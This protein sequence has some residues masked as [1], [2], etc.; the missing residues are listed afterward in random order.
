MAKKK[1]AKKAVKKT[2]KKTT[3]KSAKKSTRRKGR[4]EQGHAAHMKRVEEMGM[5]EK[6]T[7]PIKVVF[8]GAGSAFLERLFVDLLSMPGARKGEIALVDID[9]ERL[10]L[11]QQM[12]EKVI[13]AEGADWTVRAT[14]HRRDVL[15]G[16]DYII[17]CIEVSGTECVRHDNDIPAQY[18]VEQCI[19]DT[20]GPGGLMKALRTV[21]VFL[22]VL[23][24]IEELCPDAYVFNYTNPMSIMCLAA[25]MVS[26][27]KVFGFCHSV[28]GT[29]R[30]LARYA[31]VDY[32][33]LQWTC[34]GINH[35]AWFTELACGGEDLYPRLMKE[36]QEGTDLWEKD[37]VRFDMMQHFG[38][39]VTESSGHF[40]EYLPYYRKRPDL[41]KRYMREKYLGASGFYATNWPDW[42]VA[43]D[44]RR[45]DVISGKQAHHEGR[46]LE[47]ASYC[48]EAIETNRPFCAHLTVPN[49][50][51]I[52]NL[53]DDGVVEVACMVDR[54]GVVPTYFGYLPP[55]LAAIC[56]MNINMIEL[57]ALAC[58]ERSLDTAT[59]AL[60]LDPLTAAVCSPAEIRAMAGELFEAERE[61]L[62]DF[63]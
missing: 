35:L 8:L 22:D 21:P 16:A 5:R 31:G 20:V 28:Q 6:I 25:S 32:S 58:V 3:K 27:A 14:T 51:L 33:D 19:G 7:R 40:S 1:A 9:T 49:V 60:L 2:A 30:A 13:A 36:A 46:S 61:F 29:S 34:G 54:N 24:D 57:A 10:E 52:E 18:G 43:C 12:C 15:A 45:R 55:Q 48:I 17:N 59:H 26:D 11:A 44:Q 38:C 53:P 39:F 47:Y 42:R 56:R 62:P 23:Y 41:I 4:Q 37:P 50:G 63:S